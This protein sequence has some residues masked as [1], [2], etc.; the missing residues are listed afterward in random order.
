MLHSFLILPFLVV[1]SLHQVTAQN[2]Q[3]RDTTSSKI[4]GIVQFLRR[5]VHG[6]EIVTC[7]PDDIY[8]LM[9]SPWGKTACSVLF[10][11][12]NATVIT[13]VTSTM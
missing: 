2:L 6:R 5:L 12:P 11:S 9:G 1:S 10:S 8:T 4:E 3:P 13:S 7:N